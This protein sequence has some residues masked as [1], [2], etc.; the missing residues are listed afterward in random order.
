M[1]DDDRIFDFV[2]R[3]FSKIWLGMVVLILLI[4]I[5]TAVVGVTLFG[6]IREHGLKSIAE[7]VWDGP[8]Q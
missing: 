8:K 4:W 7:R 5:G 3:H 2:F 1:K 6:E